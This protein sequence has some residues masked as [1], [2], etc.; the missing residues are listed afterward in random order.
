MTVEDGQRETDD[1]AEGP[2]VGR[3]E[4]GLRVDRAV[5]EVG[6]ARFR[7]VVEED[8]IVETFDLGT[9]HAEAERHPPR[10]HDSGEIETL[11]DGSVS[12]P[13]FEEQLVVEKRLVVRERMIIR[14]EVVTEHQEVAADLR[15]EVVEVDVDDAVD[16]VV[17]VDDPS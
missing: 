4:E 17:H 9:E 2:A 14:K 3:S 8:S 12:V 1:R 7:K 13:V 15:R 11:P 6:A 5:H 10:E 16:D